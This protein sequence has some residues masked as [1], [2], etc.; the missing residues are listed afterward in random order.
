MAFRAVYTFDGGTPPIRGYGIASSENIDRGDVVAWNSSGV[1]T[2]PGGDANDVL[3][4]CLESVSSGSAQGPVTD[5]ALVVPFAYG[6]VYATTE[7]A[8]SSQSPAET[9]IGTIRDLDLSSSEW[10]I[11]AT[12]SGTA[13]TPQF[14]VVDVDTTRNEWHVVIAPLDVTDVFQ[15]IDASV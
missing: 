8:Q 4:Y 15:W 7:V 2:E 3:G 9:D 5:T 11:H 1:L 13:S 12:S 14:R 6:V 10:G